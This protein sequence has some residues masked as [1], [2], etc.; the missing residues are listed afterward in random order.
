[1]DLASMEPQRSGDKAAF[2]SR[3][4]AYHGLGETF[5]GDVSLEDAM[6]QAHLLDWNLRKEPI[7][8]LL[9]ANMSTKVDNYLIVRDNPFYEDDNTELETQ[10][11]SIVGKN[12][13]ILS[14]EALAEFTTGLLPMGRVETVGAAK[15]GNLV[16]ISLAL[17]MEIVIDEQGVNEVINSYL[18]SANT[19][20]GTASLNSF[21]TN[22]RPT[23]QNTIDFALKDAQSKLSFRHTMSLEDR[24]SAAL[25][26]QRMTVEYNERFQESANKLYQTK[27]DEADFYGIVSQIYPKPEEENKRGTTTWLNRVD[28]LMNIWH[29]PSI[30]TIKNTKW[31]VFNAIEEDLQ[32]NRSVRQGNEENFFLSGTGF[33]ETFNKRKDSIMSAVLAW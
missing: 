21:V 10:A 22:I 20:D 3:I 33:D 28:N 32:W 13:S 4:P 9:P 26:T 29:G 14:N 1:M 17:D 11:L 6:R 23:C 5:T 24:M 18:V 27:V 30:E 31:G 19:H 2:A 8:D 16:F 15:F 7:A 25:R 12:Y